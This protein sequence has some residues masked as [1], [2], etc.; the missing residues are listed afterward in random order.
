MPPFEWLMDISS[1]AWLKLNSSFPRPA[2]PTICPV[3]EEAAACVLLLTPEHLQSFL[4]SSASRIHIQTVSKFCVLRLENKSIIPNF[5]PSVDLVVQ[6]STI[7]HRGDGSGLKTGF[8][9]SHQVH[10]PCNSWNYLREESDH[11]APCSSGLRMNPASSPLHGPFR[12][13]PLPICAVSCHPL[14]VSPALTLPS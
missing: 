8:T 12:I 11:V 3:L 2:P 1:I 13:W 9:P 10:C 14:T 5:S 4:T 7:R 6:A